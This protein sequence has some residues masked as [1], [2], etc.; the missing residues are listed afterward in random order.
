MEKNL[1]T[2][3]I[4][5][6]KSVGAIILL[7][8]LLFQGCGKESMDQRIKQIDPEQ[9]KEGGGLSLKVGNKD[10]VILKSDIVNRRDAPSS[11]PDMK[12]LLTRREIRDL[13]SFLATLKEE[14]EE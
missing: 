4:R 9:T 2:I 11:M 6:K 3:L 1:N 13:V 12:N 14:E 5:N 10:T 8:T 7:S